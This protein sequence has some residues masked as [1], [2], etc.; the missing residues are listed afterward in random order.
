M[1]TLTFPSGFLWGA[2]T[3][4]HQVEGG[5]WANDWWDWEH[6][7]G[8]PCREPSGDAC[9]QYHRYPADL[10][11]LAGLGFN[12]YRFSIEWAR[13][14]PEEGE[15]SRAALE[16]YRQV[17][18]A[19]HEQ[20]L[21][22]VVTFHHFTSPRWV[23]A[24]GG[25]ENERTP[26]RFARYCERAV[27]HLGDLIGMACTINEPN[28]VAMYGYRVG[29]FPPGRADYEARRRANANFIDAHRRAVDAIKSGPGDARA[30]LAL[31]MAEWEGV[32]GGEERLSSMREPMEDVFLEAV[33]GDDFFGVQTYTRER[34]GPGGPLGP[35]EGAETTLMGYEFRPE[36]LEA[37]VRRAWEATERVPI[38]VTESGI[39]TD[40]DT[41]RVAFVAGAL[42]GVHRCL[43][44]GIEIGGYFYWSSLDNFEW[45]FG[46]APTFGLVTVDR[47]TME[48]IPK[49]SASWLGTVAKANA[50]EVPG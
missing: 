23:S 2:S 35:P 30:G 7:P 44:D 20:G 14:E 13:I 40:D 15:F 21:L 45:V 42:Q 24:D 32:D 38:V 9:D 28:I 39:A 12:A 34:I 5:N 19:C 33:R 11:M 29:V 4:A 1:A 3:S 47:E 37:T 27:S 43:A 36:A 41:R 26:E 18:G 22:P 50:L 10:A 31:S 48:R 16:H 8:T 46:Y 17:L 49:P 25:W 6:R